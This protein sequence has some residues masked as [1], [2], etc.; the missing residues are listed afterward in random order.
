MKQSTKR[1]AEIGAGVVTAA[2]LAAAAAY[3]ISEKTT[4]E[5]RTKA[6]AWVEKARKEIARHAATA[7]HFGEGEYK[8]IVDKTIKKYGSLE[9]VSVSDIIKTARDLKSEWKRIQARAK[10]VTAKAPKRKV[11]G[12]KKRK[13][14]TRTAKRQ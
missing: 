5:Q 11:A 4:K 3:W 2:A 8:R 7:R 13:S 14:A 10:Q 12:A 9:D 1:A 6:K